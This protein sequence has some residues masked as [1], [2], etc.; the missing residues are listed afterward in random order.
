MFHCTKYFRMEEHN[1]ICREKWIDIN[2]GESA[3]VFCQEEDANNIARGQYLE[4]N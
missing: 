2:C 1:Y 4:D 3:G